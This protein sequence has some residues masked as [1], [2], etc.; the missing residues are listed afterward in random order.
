MGGIPKPLLE[1]HGR[2]MLQRAVDACHTAGCEPITVVG[3]SLREVSFAWTPP[4]PHPPDDVRL[5]PPPI[6]P[7]LTWTREDPPFGGPAAAVV[8]GLATWDRE[9]EWAFVLACDLPRIEAA[10]ARLRN[11]MLLLPSDTEGMCVADGSSRPQWLTAVYRT[12]ALREAAAAIPDGGRDASMRA[13]LSDLAIA[14]VAASDDITD[15]VDTW[16]DYTRLS[17]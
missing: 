6:D 13:L 16:D 10:V 3:A 1:V 4:I 17:R 11:D 12:R 7:A 9:P 14:V 2:S 5:I 8:A 15:D